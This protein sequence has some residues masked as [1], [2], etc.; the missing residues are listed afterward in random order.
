MASRT[1][2]Q[3]VAQFEAD[4]FHVS[5]LGD[6]ATEWGRRSNSMARMVSKMFRTI[7][8]VMQ[9]IE[10]AACAGPVSLPSRYR[11]E[12]IGCLVRLMTSDRYSGGSPNECT[13]R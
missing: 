6:E 11:L 3:C 5:A 1:E 10:L 7:A 4:A 8:R 13:R 2:F 12:A 9:A